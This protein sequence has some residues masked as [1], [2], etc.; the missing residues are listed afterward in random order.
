MSN[1]INFTC[2]VKIETLK[3]MEI[4][5]PV[6]SADAHDAKTIVRTKN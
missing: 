5:R 3:V 6:Y 2:Q 1:I 4:P